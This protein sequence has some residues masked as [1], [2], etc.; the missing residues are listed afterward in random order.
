MVLL[1]SMNSSKVTRTHLIVRCLHSNDT[2]IL[3]ADDQ[4]CTRYIILSNKYD[5]IDCH[6][7]VPG[8]LEVGS[9]LKNAV[10]GD[11]N[12][13]CFVAHACTKFVSLELS[14]I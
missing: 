12:L 9:V 14:L 7:M 11:D 8:T 5:R 13:S 6:C 2:Y 1:Y 3:H 4:I 10:I